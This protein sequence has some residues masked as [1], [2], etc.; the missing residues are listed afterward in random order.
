MAHA[1]LVPIKTAADGTFTT[2]V[3]MYGVIEAIAVRLGSLDTPDIT[4][5][6]GLT[7]GAILAVTGVAADAR[8][9]PRVKVQTSV[10]ADADPVV[11]DKPAVTGICRVAVAG[12]GNAKSGVVV[13]LF[14][15]D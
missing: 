9:H 1:H 10:G 6:D 15:D 3:R 5:T 2:D 13:V 12:G 14:N 8:Y 7:G 4:V 11:L